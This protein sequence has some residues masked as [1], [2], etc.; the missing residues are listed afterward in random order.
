MLGL[1]QGPQ[2]PLWDQPQWL[3]TLFFAWGVGGR[4]SLP[5]RV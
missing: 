3:S 5:D 4:G 2:E 1:W